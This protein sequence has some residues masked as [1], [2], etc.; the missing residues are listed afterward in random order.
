M[1]LWLLPNHALALTEPGHLPGGRLGNYPESGF[2]EV[3]SNGRF[4]SLT[5]QADTLRYVRFQVLRGK[6]LPSK[7]PRESDRHT[8]ARLHCV[9]LIKKEG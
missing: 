3:D 7:M 8:S 2:L 1:P 5:R 9:I 4:I 6:D